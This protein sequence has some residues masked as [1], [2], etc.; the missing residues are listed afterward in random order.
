MTE[1]LNFPSY[2]IAA[3]ALALIGSYVVGKILRLSLMVSLLGGLAPLALPYSDLSFVPRVAAL[4][5]LAQIAGGWAMAVCVAILWVLLRGVVKT[6]AGP[7]GLLRLIY[8]GVLCVAL[9]VVAALFAK[10]ELLAAHAPGWRS[11]GGIVLLCATLLSMSLAFVRIFRTAALLALWSFASLVLA[12]EIFLQKMPT[13]IAR[14]DLR[15]IE[16]SVESDLFRAAVKRLSIS[17]E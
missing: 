14:D 5:P 1:L 2:F 12:S 3:V 11:T 6:G 15:R 10:P 9:A 17:D 16:S 4:A 8:M 13:E 7:L